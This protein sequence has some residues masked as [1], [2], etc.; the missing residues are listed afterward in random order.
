MELTPGSEPARATTT[1]ETSEIIS[2]RV[3]DLRAGEL[4]A[5]IRSLNFAAAASAL[6]GADSGWRDT[7]LAA[8]PRRLRTE[9]I[10]STLR[11]FTVS[12]TTRLRTRLVLVATGE[13]VTADGGEAPASQPCF[14]VCR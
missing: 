5:R 2:P 9:V 11:P 6:L 7:S 8:P 12:L 14:H 13:D 4:T 3:G 1:E 10:H